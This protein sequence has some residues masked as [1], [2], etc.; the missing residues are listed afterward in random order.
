MEK[1]LIATCILTLFC[2]ISFSQKSPGS[3]NFWKDVRY[4]GSLGLNFFN[5][6][7][8]ASISPSAIYPISNEFSAGTSLNFNYSKFNENK[9]VAYGGSLLTLYN[10]IP[11]IQFSA[12][13]EQLRIN[14]KLETLTSLIEDNY[15]SPALFLGIGYS[16]YNV[17]VGLRYN[18]LYDENRSIYNN[19]ILP[20]IRVFF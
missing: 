5:S 7:F 19:S 11:Q 17:T 4:G 2:A 3:N 12:E 14:R 18:V 15:W 10:P 8:N 20:F 6:G 9:L 1:K 16:S 13:L